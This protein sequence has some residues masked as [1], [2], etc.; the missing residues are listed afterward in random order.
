MNRRDRGIAVLEGRGENVLR[1]LLELPNW[2]RARRQRRLLLG[3]SG[4]LVK[5][6]EWV[7]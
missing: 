1:R 5:A 7:S 2:I 4:C 3:A 6:T